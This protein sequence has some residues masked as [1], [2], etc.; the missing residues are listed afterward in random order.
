MFFFSVSVREETRKHALLSR[1][2]ERKMDKIFTGEMSRQGTKGG[3]DCE[4]KGRGG[5][6]KTHTPERQRAQLS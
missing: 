6:D 5:G 2:K 4:V 3:G 1:P